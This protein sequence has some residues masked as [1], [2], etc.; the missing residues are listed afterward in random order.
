MRSAAFALLLLV[1]PAAA[2]RAQQTSATAPAVISVPAT[3]R[4]DIH[5][6]APRG[7]WAA[8]ITIRTGTAGYEGTFQNPDGPGTYP[9]AAVSVRG[10]SLIVTMAGEATGSIFYLRARSDSVVGMMTS[11]ANGD[12]PVTG[13]RISP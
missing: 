12:T 5:S 13:I 9:V 11:I 2:L 3:Y 7:T 4:V 8:L 1:A 10:D 6:P